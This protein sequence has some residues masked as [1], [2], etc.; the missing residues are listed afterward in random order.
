MRERKKINLKITLVLLNI[1]Y[2]RCL[3]PD[4]H[5]LIILDPDSA[6]PQLFLDPDPHYS[7][8]VVLDTDPAATQTVR[9]RSLATRAVSRYV[10]TGSVPA[11]CN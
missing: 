3:D 10:G 2:S 8:T 5:Y 6:D 4:P 11:Y 7:N 1:L 9:I